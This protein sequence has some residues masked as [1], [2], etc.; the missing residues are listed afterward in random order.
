M[1]LLENIDYNPGED[2]MQQVFDKLNQA[3]DTIN[4]T[5]G[6]GSDGEQIRKASGD[7]FDFEYFAQAQAL[8]TQVVESAI[9]V[10]GT[11]FSLPI[12]YAPSTTG[13]DNVIHASFTL[14]SGGEIACVFVLKKNGSIIK[15][16]NHT[17]INTVTDTTD[18]STVVSYSFA[19]LNAAP[20][21]SY[22]IVVTTSASTTMSDYSV[23]LQ[24]SLT[25]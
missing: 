4:A 15:T 8:K 6:G 2:T 16:L 5:L 21:D 7:D 22:Q 3:I 24:S 12:Q 17:I 23:I 19:D 18:Y 14:F 25:V 10:T 11:N 1:A 20:D 13:R 9:P